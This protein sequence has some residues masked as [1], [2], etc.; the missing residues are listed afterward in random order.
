MRVRTRGI[1][2]LSA[3][4]AV[5]TVGT[6]GTVVPAAPAAATVTP[7]AEPTARPTAAKSGRLTADCQG[8]WLPATPTAADIMAGRLEFVDLP[9]VRIGRNVNWHTNPHRNRSWAM[10]FHSLRWMAR[11]VAEYETTGDRA[12]LN[13]AVEVAKDWV[14]DNPRGGRTTNRYAWD[15]HPVA[16]RAPALVCLSRHVKADWL[17]R[18]LREHATVLAN[19]ALYEKGHNHGLDQD[20]GLLSIGCR[21]GER[22]WS[23]LAVRR[24]ASSAKLAIDA[25]GALQEQAPRYGVYVHRRMT[26]AMEKITGCG[27][28]VPAEMRRRYDLLASYIVHATQP[29]GYMVPIGDGG[30]D[31]RPAGFTPEE[32]EKEATDKEATEQAAKKTTREKPVKV[33]RRAGYVFGRTAW[34]DPESAYYS[35]RFG[36]GLKYHGHEDHLGVTYYAHGRDVLVDVGFHSYEKTAY[37]YWTMSPEA[38]NVPIVTGKRFRPRTATRLDAAKIGGERQTYKLSDTAYGVRRTRSVLVN[39][40]KDV[41]AV[42]DTAAKGARIRNL[43]HFPAD[44]KVLANRG[45]HVVVGEGGAK[46]FRVSLVQL[47]MPSC[48][49]IGGQQVK[50]GQT[51]PFQGWVSPGYMRKEKAPAVVSPAAP[52]LL[53]VIVPGT[54]EPEVSCSGG[55]VTVQTPE[56]PVTFRATATGGLA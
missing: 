26:T 25:D 9:P 19:P 31:V 14:K 54:A 40:G 45:G 41:M 7:A 56:G 30:P 29:N 8:D 16:L 15:E 1:A 18:S 34:G 28:K 5:G 3:L 35:I 22:K 17:T 47:A 43:W 51:K 4:L 37:R 46:G 32:A 36:P 44:L 27:L 55:K 2:L 21:L 50:I 13:R 12:Y 33:F 38:H 49:P 23:T 52:A 48:K 24:M 53:T 42:L 20:I 11:L 39:H 6:V 10:V